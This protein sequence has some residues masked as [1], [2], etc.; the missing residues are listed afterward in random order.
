MVV[1][2]AITVCASDAVQGPFWYSTR[3][4]ENELMTWGYEGGVK[5]AA[6]YGP[7]LPALAPYPIQFEQE[8]FGVFVISVEGKLVSTAASMTITSGLLVSATLVSA[9]LV[10]AT[11]V[12]GVLASA[13]ASIAVLVSVFTSLAPCEESSI[14]ASSTFVSRLESRAE[15]EL[16]ASRV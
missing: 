15:S 16:A 6:M 13:P 10:S 1:R 9:T 12:S 3:S 8:V 4:Y 2:N 5:R 7:A 11:L 14:F